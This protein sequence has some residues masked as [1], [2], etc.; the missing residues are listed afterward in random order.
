MSIQ[1]K[2]QDRAPKT[3]RSRIPGFLLLF[4]LLFVAL[5][6]LERLRGQWA[7]KVWAKEMT[8]K[9]EILETKKLWPPA[10][11][12]MTDFTR[13]LSNAV[14]K[15]PQRLCS[16]AGEISPIVPGPAGKWLNLHNHNLPAAFDDLAALERFVTAGEDDPGLINLMIRIAVLGITIDVMWDALQAEGWTDEQLA[17]LQELCQQN[18]N[19]LSQLPR[20]IDAVRISHVS[21]VE[22]FRRHA[23]NEIIARDEPVFASFG[24]QGAEIER[25]AAPRLWRQWIFHPL[26]SFAWADQEKLVYLK[27]WQK[28]IIA[29]RKAT[30]HGSWKQLHSDLANNESSYHAPFCAWRFYRRLPL[31][32]DIPGPDWHAIKAGEYPYA[33]FSRAWSTSLHNLTLNEMALAAVAIKR[34]ELRHH[35]PPSTLAELSPEILKDAPRDFMDGN[36]LIYQTHLGGTFTLRS[37]GGDCVWP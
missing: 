25:A 32:D 27:D 30:S 29:L 34:Y 24:V 19:L 36:T 28:H 20:A 18:R 23:Y 2:H 21:D 13:S 35:M 1:L 22:W 31:R 15:L 33:S 14:H 8:A 11:P 4:A 3:R 37:V 12:E 5:L 7:L 10:S 6:A 26:W 9:G 16:Y 17:A